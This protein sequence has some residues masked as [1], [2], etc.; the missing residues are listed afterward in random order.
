MTA[1]AP[2][3]KPNIESELYPLTIL[4]LNFVGFL[5]QQLK[6]AETRLCNTGLHTLTIIVYHNGLHLILHRLVA[7]FYS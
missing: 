2:L 6:P 4:Y 5:H 1:L 3:R 7:T